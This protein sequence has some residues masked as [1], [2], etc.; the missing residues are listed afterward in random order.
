MTATVTIDA[1]VCGFKTTAIVESADEQ[2]AAFKISTDCEKIEAIARDVEALGPLDAYQ[3]I[4]PAGRS[5]LLVTF[6]DRLTGCCAGCVVPSGLFKSLQAA[7]RLA[8]PQEAHILVQ[9][10]PME[11]GGA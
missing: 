10:S 7:T 1:G 6:Q 3:E 2:F 4:S 8:L 5:I 9:I 11:S